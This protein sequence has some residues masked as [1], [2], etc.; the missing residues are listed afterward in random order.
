MTIQ[1]VKKE[2]RLTWNNDEKTVVLK[3]GMLIGNEDT[4]FPNGDYIRVVLDEAGMNAAIEVD[5]LIDWE[6]PKAKPKRGNK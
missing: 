2:H 5:V 3:P 4:I 6:P 1:T